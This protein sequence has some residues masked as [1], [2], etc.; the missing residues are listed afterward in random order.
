LCGNW[1]LKEMY[2][3]FE[4]NHTPANFGRICFKVMMSI[5]EFESIYNEAT[6]ILNPDT[7]P[8]NIK[9]INGKFRVTAMEEF[10]SNHREIIFSEVFRM[11]ELEE[12]V[13]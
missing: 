2:E 12:E 6:D 1:L 11:L 8:K 13:V 3:A 4:N 10:L 5:P 9:R 7:L